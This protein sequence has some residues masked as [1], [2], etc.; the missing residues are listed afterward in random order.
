[1]RK[2]T[3]QN[4]SRSVTWADPVVSKRFSHSHRPPIGREYTELIRRS[5]ESA[6]SEFFNEE[7][8]ELQWVPIS[9]KTNNGDTQPRDRSIDK[10]SAKSYS[11]IENHSESKIKGLWKKFVK[12]PILK[13]M[14]SPLKQRQ[15]N[16]SHARQRMNH[17]IELKSPSKQQ[18]NRRSDLLSLSK[19]QEMDEITWNGKPQQEIE[20]HLDN[21]QINPLR[22][23]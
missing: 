12:L 8:E 2:N 18:M 17:K 15:I 20:D 21:I 10:D 22:E 19:H 16:T 4:R 1:M 13:T 11:E 3:L 6:E 14:L 23:R 9:S 7:M 5:L